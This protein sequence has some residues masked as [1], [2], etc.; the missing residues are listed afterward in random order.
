MINLIISLNSG[1]VD[2]RFFPANPFS[3]ILG[4]I[5][6]QFVDNLYPKSS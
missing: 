6:L 3:A 5:D 4:I 1:Q 2:R